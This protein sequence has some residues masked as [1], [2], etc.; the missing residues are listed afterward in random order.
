MAGM[1]YLPYSEITGV[2]NVIA[3]GHPRR[4]TVLTLSHWPDST[5]PA[6]LKRD[7]S[8]EIALAY[9]ER[10][11]HHVD[12]S[13]VSNNHFD[14]DGFMA[15][16]ALCHPDAAL[17]DRT[18]VA[19]V[20]RAGDFGWTDDDRWARAAFALGTLK[21]AGLSPLP[22]ETFEGSE[23]DRVSRLYQEMLARFGDVAADLDAHE[24]L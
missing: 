10:P 23:P 18:L 11:E 15:V 7:L 16:W 21:T 17:A 24:A 19:E 13:V 12:A 22:P 14:I 3:D 4:S 20:A 6:E 9:L 8:A 5:T 2:P 1:R